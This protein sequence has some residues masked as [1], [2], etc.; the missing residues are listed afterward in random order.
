MSYGLIDYNT[1]SAIAS[2]LREKTN[3]NA[4]YYPRDMANAIRQIPTGG[5]GAGFESPVM[6][7]ISQYM[8]PNYA[9]DPHTQINLTNAVAFEVASQMPVNAMV[10]DSDAQWDF[11]GGKLKFYKYTG[12]YNTQI[13]QWNS[14]KYNNGEYPYDLVDTTVTGEIYGLCPTEGTTNK[15]S[16]LDM[17]H[18][19]DYDYKISKAFCGEYTTSLRFAYNYCPNL[20]EAACGPYV[21]DMSGAYRYCPNLRTAVVGPNVK[22]LSQAYMYDEYIEGDVEIPKAYILKDSFN[23]CNRLANIYLGTDKLGD[24]EYGTYA[25]YTALSMAFARSNY[26]I[27]RNIVL[28]NKN[29][30]DLFVQTNASVGNI[31]SALNCK[32]ADEEV[33]A[34]PIEINVNNNGYNVVRYKCNTTTN[35]YVYCME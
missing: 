13:C 22:N 14:E 11:G 29:S 18:M 33:L 15:V 24:I 19:F 9:Y 20:I 6:F 17:S 27:R 3:S 1:V 25:A 16:I 26:S 23:G 8:T 12:S 34:E 4:N 35:V 2:A 7:S 5:G 31:V 28:A 32:L 21:E 30:Y 10:F